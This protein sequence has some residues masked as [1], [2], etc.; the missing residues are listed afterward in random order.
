MNQVRARTM[1][2][3]VALRLFF[4]ALAFLLLNLWSLVKTL[5]YGLLPFINWRFPLA[6]WRLWLWKVIKQRLGLLLE[7]PVLV[8]L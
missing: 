7:L 2:T 1:S 4:V 6:L 8:Y 3:S 5:A